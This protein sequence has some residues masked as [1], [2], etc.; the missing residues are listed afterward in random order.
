[1]MEDQR[2][3]F[4]IRSPRVPYGHR[5]L[6]F[7]VIAAPVP[8]FAWTGGAFSGERE[9]GGSF[10]EVLLREVG[11]FCGWAMMGFIYISPALIAGALLLVLMSWF[12]GDESRSSRWQALVALC[13][14]L[15]TLYPLWK[16]VSVLMR[17]AG[18][19]P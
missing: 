19:G 6:V 17:I 13:I 3:Q 1:M 4:A 15:A 18:G 2:A 9:Y 8:W 12:D 7:A 10:A 11:E 14:A 5:A 16:I